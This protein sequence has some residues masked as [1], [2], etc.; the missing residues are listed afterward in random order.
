MKGRYNNQ[1]WKQKNDRDQGGHG[2]YY[3]YNGGLDVLCENDQNC[4]SDR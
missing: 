1:H 3:D 2:D 4:V